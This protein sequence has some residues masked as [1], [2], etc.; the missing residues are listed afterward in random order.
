MKIEVDKSEIH[1]RCVCNKP[2]TVRE[3]SKR[4]V[5]IIRLDDVGQVC[6]VSIATL[7]KYRNSPDGW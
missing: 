5:D 3:E 7:L 1:G 2:S 4:L 6:G